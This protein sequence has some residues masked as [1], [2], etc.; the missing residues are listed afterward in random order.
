TFFGFYLDHPQHQASSAVTGL[1]EQ[2]S[3]KCSSDYPEKPERLFDNTCH[4]RKE[5]AL[6]SED[7]CRDFESG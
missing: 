7:E 4:K 3:C 5:M 6:W 1:Q 2:Y